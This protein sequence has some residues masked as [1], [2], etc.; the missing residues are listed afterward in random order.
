[1]LTI[2]NLSKGQKI[3]LAATLFLITGTFGFMQPFVPLYYASAG[4]NKLQVGLMAGLGSAGAAFLQPALGRLAEKWDSRRYVMFLSAIIVGACFLSFLLVKSW[5]MF[6]PLTILAWSGWQY[7]NGVGPVLV[8][9]LGGS[10]SSYA[11]Y[12]VW[13]SVGYLVVCLLTGFV[14]PARPQMPRGDLNLLFTLGPLL[15]FLLLIPVFWLPDPK[16]LAKGGETETLSPESSKRLLRFMIAYF[17]YHIA[18]YGASANLSLYMKSLHALPQQITGMF[19]LGVICEICFM[20]F[21]GRW[22]D[23]N[24]RKPALLFAFILMPLRLLLYT[25]ATDPWGVIAVQAL[26]GLNFGIVGTVAVTYVNDLAQNGGRSIAQS[27]MALT[28]SLGNAL[29]PILCGAIV[30]RFGFSAMFATMAGIG[31]ISVVLLLT[32]VDETIKKPPS[33]GGL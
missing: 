11:N 2:H 15:F 12:R 24:G 18:L 31:V 8:G 29:G 4:L 23:K 10:G 6:L 30:E 13:G 9:R 21:V 26:H 27:R 14:L 32:I 7:L 25:L 16:R 3:A 28:M 5:W 17:P 1:M 19:A 22:S 20:R 33:I